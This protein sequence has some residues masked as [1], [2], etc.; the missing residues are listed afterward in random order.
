MKIYSDLSQR[1]KRNY[2]V[3][4]V[5]RKFFAWS[6]ISIALAWWCVQKIMSGKKTDQ[7]NKDQD[8]RPYQYD[9]DFPQ[10]TPMINRKPPNDQVGKLGSG[11]AGLWIEEDKEGGSIIL[12][13]KEGAEHFWEYHTNLAMREAWVSFE[14]SLETKKPKPG[15]FVLVHKSGPWGEWDVYQ[16]GDTEEEVR[17]VAVDFPSLYLGVQFCIERKV[18]FGEL[19]WDVWFL[20]TDGAY[21]LLDEKDGSPPPDHVATNGE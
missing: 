19:E 14:K 13:E 8:K 15:D 4:N 3:K 2:T 18:R 5:K 16:V 9:T 20:D 1:K 7:N 11:W 21:Y 17:A 6:S 10:F 12:V